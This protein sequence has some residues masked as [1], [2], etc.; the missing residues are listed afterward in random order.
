MSTKKFQSD[1]DALGVDITT[2]EMQV[3]R[4]V[5]LAAGGT[6]KPVQYGEIAQSF[7]SMVKKKYTKAYIYR[8]LKNLEENGFIVADTFQTPRAYMITEP[9]LAKALETRRNA[10]MAENL[11]KKQDLTT[12]L[13]RLREIKKQDLAL[14]L[15]N[16]LVG[17][18]YVEESFVI[19][20]IENVRSTIIQEF[21]EGAQEGDVVRVLG[22]SSTLAEGLGPGGVTELKLILSGF[23]GVKVYGLLTPYSQNG[24]NVNLLASHLSPMIKVFEDAAAT[25]NIKL[26]LTR[27][28][29]NTYR[30]LTLN[31]DKMLLYLTHAKESDAAALI[32]RRD[33]PG[34]IDDALRTF[35]EL[36]ESG[37]DV[38][39]IVKQ[40]L[41]KQQ[42][43]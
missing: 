14:L 12:K 13:N 26:R 29:I 9:S 7:E 40:I 35:N 33:N 42:A 15:H 17:I 41:S 22:H 8:Q 43:S 18:P 6:G 11:K 25:G 32:H 38:L 10:K 27:E 24:A 23:R 36:W 20:G 19:E 39:E 37:I 34:L 21:A 2:N 1:L 16:Q 31:D 28:P 30:M 5:L 3:F 4:A